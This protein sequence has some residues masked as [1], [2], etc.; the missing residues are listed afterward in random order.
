[1]KQFG[2]V[3][4]IIS[5]L[6]VYQYTRVP[7][8]ITPKEFKA[9]LNTSPNALLIDLRSSKEFT[10]GHLE[11]AM[12]IDCALK[13]YKSRVAELDT[14][15]PVFLY[16]KDGKQNKEAANYFRFSGFDLIHELKGGFLQWMLEGLPTTPAEIVLP[17][18]LTLMEFSRYLDLEHYVLVDYYIPWDNN[19]QK[20]EPI[21]DELAIKY[22]AKVKIIRIN[23]DQYKWLATEQGITVLPTY[24]FYENGNLNLTL[25]GTTK[26]SV[27][28]GQFSGNEYVELK[29]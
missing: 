27:I 20:M 24:Q 17:D 10:A 21:I 18:E 3:I 19:C 22:V 2:L 1:M 26:R 4:I 15:I 8:P 5:V 25:E 9:A 16:S 23:V 13:S 11:G 29:D 6:V 28:E 7:A 12:N 14:T